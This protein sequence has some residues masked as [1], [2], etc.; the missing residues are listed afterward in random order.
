MVCWPS[1]KECWGNTSRQYLRTSYLS[2]CHYGSFSGKVFPNSKMVYKNAFV[3]Y[4]MLGYLKNISVSIWEYQ[5]R[6]IFYCTTFFLLHQAIGGNIMTASPISD[7]NPI[8]MAARCTL[9]LASSGGKW[10]KFFAVLDMKAL[11]REVLS[12]PPF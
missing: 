3:F 12:T 1:N 9:T 8:L 4:D 10:G 5:L 6:F 2:R 11:P 7:L